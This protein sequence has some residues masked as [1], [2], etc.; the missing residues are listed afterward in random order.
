MTAIERRQ[1][2][3]RILTA[4]RSETAPRLARELGVCV[5][6]IRNDIL[7]LTA[8]FPLETTRGNGGCVRVPDWFHP[9]RNIL[10]VEQQNVLSQLME[11]ANERQREVLAQMLME[12][13]SPK[14]RQTATEGINVKSRTRAS[15][16]GSPLRTSA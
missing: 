5:N 2:I 3:M 9:H 16:K 12:Y 6:T 13:G 15:H 4:R 14:D 1:E 7:T 8:E 10:S 11:S